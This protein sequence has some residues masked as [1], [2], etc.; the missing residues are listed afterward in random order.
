MS[1]LSPQ[2]FG[3]AL[4][5]ILWVR[6]VRGP[7]RGLGF[8]I[9]SLL[10]IHSHVGLA[11]VLVI[12]AFSLGGYGS[13]LALK[14]SRAAGTVAIVALTAAFIYAQTYSF[15]AFLLPGAW[16]VPALRTAGLSFLFFKVV[17]VAIDYG[18][19]TI[20]K[21]PFPEYLIYCFNF[22]AYLAGPIQR[23][24]EFDEQWSG[25]R[26]PLPAELEP[27]LDATLRILRGLVKKYVL[28]T[29]VAPWALLP[30][31][32]IGTE[33]LAHVVAGVY[34]FYIYLY[35]DFSGYC[36]VVIGTGALMGVRPPENFNF[37]FLSPNVAQ[38]WLRV[39][40]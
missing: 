3:L 14:R 22:T 40:R 13:A 36:D 9:A 18:G 26:E 29:Y 5:A 30:G 4:A 10:F 33:S 15:L 35:L 1:L 24:Q 37:P 6:T 21:L 16:I 23:F 12:A 7:M 8:A 28:A 31:A 25:A 32:T 27:H 34:L 20:E 39:H 38:F 19:G 11:G 17:H 2:F